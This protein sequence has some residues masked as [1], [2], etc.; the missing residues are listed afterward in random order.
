MAD[1][2]VTGN[3]ISLSRGASSLIR[4]EFG[5]IQTAIATKID[6]TGDTY[7]G[8]HDMT[9]ATVT[10]ATQSQ[11]DNSTK[12]AT[13][14]YADTIK[15]Y[16]NSLSMAAG[17]LPVGG[18]AGQYLKKSSAT[19]YDAS[20][21][22]ITKTIEVLTSGTSWVC[23]AAITSVK[24]TVVGGGGGG[25][26]TATSA[27]VGGG[28]GGCAVKVFASTPGASYT[29]AIG[30][31]GAA[32]TGDN[33]AGSTGG[34]T[35]FNTGAV[36]VTG[37]GGTGGLASANGR[38]IGGAAT[39]G[40]VNIRGG[41]GAAYSSYSTAHGGDSAFGSGG[42]KATPTAAQGYGAGGAGNINGSAAEAGTAGVI[43]LEY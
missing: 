41:Y 12:P 39:N 6:N 14:A 17:N 22:T 42:E 30:A 31:A 21:G 35:T 34:N 29:Y 2:S 26:R 24:M 38:S 20:W 13:T 7:T 18:T 32:A 11:G 37:S 1:Y 8:T 27:A 5:L 16:A 43:I 40:D 28:A 9:G 10:V 36:T 15:A 23:P 19:N 4:V 25:G 3:P 33:L